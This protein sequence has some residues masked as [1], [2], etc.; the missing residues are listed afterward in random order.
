MNDWSEGAKLAVG[1]IVICVIVGAVFLVLSTTRNQMNTGM[2][3]LQNSLGAMTQS[4]FDDYDQK[5]VSGLQAKSSVKIFEGS[6]I[7]ILIRNKAQGNTAKSIIG[8]NYGALLN[9]SPATVASGGVKYM[10]TWAP[11]QVTADAKGVVKPPASA[12]GK[13]GTFDPVNATDVYVLTHLTAGKAVT[14]YNTELPK[15]T[16]TDSFY[17]LNQFVDGNGKLVYNMNYKPM[18][19]SATDG[20]VGN[21]FKYLSEL[22]RDTTGSIVGIVFTQ[23]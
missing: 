20:Y 18:D 4:Q 12:S 22:I 19:A 23:Q 6:P 16:E 15:A 5:F 21:N 9:D 2:S 17:T 3:T 13:T 1:L 7:S 11:S 14:G 10:N 8:F